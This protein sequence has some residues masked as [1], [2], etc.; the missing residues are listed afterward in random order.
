MGW[1]VW[2]PLGTTVLGLLASWHI[3]NVKVFI[4]LIPLTNWDPGEAHTHTYR[5]TEW[6]MVLIELESWELHVLGTVPLIKLSLVAKSFLVVIDIT[7]EACVT[8]ITSDE[9][10]SFK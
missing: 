2:L 9:L 6:H 3:P 4:K 1:I 8:G 7:F 10:H 5:V